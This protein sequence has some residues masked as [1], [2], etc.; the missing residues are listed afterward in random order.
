MTVCVFEMGSKQNEDYGDKL[1][2]VKF[3][4]ILVYNESDHSLG[5]WRNRRKNINSYVIVM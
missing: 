5:N 1:S 2:T 3:Y 4:A